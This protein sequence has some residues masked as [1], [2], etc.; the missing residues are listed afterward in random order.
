[1]T[2]ARELHTRFP[3]LLQ[4]LKE[5][6][7]YYKQ[8]RDDLYDLKM[9]EIERGENPVLYP[10]D[11]IRYILSQQSFTDQD[12]ERFS[13]AHPDKDFDPSQY[14]CLLIGNNPQYLMGHLYKS[15]H[16]NGTAKL[17]KPLRE[18][19]AA[20]T[21]K[22]SDFWQRTNF[23]KADAEGLAI[24]T[25]KDISALIKKYENVGGVA[26]KRKTRDDLLDAY[27]RGL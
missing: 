23:Y 22:E 14:L 3:L 18:K 10:I 7:R 4:R 13:A 20:L 11:F 8:I 26:Q 15:G 2:R 5:H 19:L 12:R 21:G 16:N 9:E 27:M 17:P 25:Q 24:D 6:P 1:M